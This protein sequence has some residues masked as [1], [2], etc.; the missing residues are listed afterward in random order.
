MFR[1]SAV[2]PFSLKQ[3]LGADKMAYRSATVRTAVTH[4]LIF[5]I[6]QHPNGDVFIA[7]AAPNRLLHTILLYLRDLFRNIEG[8]RGLVHAGLIQA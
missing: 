4:E 2:A 6:A 7:L 3:S 1:G 5:L 8:S